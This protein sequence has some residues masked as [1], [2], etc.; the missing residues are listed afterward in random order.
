MRIL[1]VEDAPGTR[2]VIQRVLETR[3]AANVD[4]AELGSQAI[5][6]LQA[7]DYDV[8]LLDH[9]LP[10]T[11]G[12]TVLEEIQR[13]R[14]R[15]VA[16]YLTGRGDEGIAQKAL[17]LGAVDYL[18]KGIDTYSSLPEIIHEAQQRWGD[19]GPLVRSH[20]PTSSSTDGRGLRD[21]TLETLLRQHGIDQLIVHDGQGNLLDTTLDDDATALLVAEQAAVWL[22]EGWRTAEEAGLES[23][24]TF[25]A[26]EGAEGLLASLGAAADVA[27]IATFEQGTSPAEA[28][29]ALRGLIPHLLEEHGPAPDA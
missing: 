10:D 24:I 4:V 13:Q 12:L 14:P 11:T 17:S 16:I 8:V 3:L 29:E 21:E 1:V 28:F 5:D 26:L 18:T 7:S 19:R 27:M 15:P 22:S 9:E 2:A 25:S 23:R 20:P 6:R